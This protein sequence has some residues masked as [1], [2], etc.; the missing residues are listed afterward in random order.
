[1]TDQPDNVSRLEKIAKTMEAGHW[2][3]LSKAVRDAAAEIERLRA[4][5]DEARRRLCLEWEEHGPV[6]L[7]KEQI[8]MRYGWEC[9]KENTDD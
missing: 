8:A 5:R 1:M 6:R 7:N 2:V 9:F 4:E 3:S